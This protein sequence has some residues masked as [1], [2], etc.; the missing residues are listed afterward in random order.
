MQ[1]RLTLL[2]TW[3]K[4]TL[5]GTD[6]GDF[7]L[8]P[9]AGDASFRRYFRLHTQNG[10]RYIVMDA[11]PEKEDCRPFVA[12]TRAWSAYNICVPNIY[13]E[14]IEQGF[15][16]LEDFGDT[17][18]FD[19]VCQADTKTQNDIYSLA[20]DALQALQ[21]MP[22]QAL[23]HNI[24]DRALLMRELRLFSD[25]LI[26]DALS[27]NL[28]NE[29]TQLLEAGF[30]LL[31][32]NALSQAL[33]VVHRDYHS[34]NLMIRG[35]QKIGI[36]DFQDAVI[37]P[38]TYDLVSLLR[39][40]Y[41]QLEPALIKKLALGFKSNSSNEQIRALPEAIFLRHF[42]LMGIQRH[43]KAAGIFARLA[44][45]DGKLGYLQD[46][47]RTFSYITEVCSKYGELQALATFLDE[48]VEPHIQA[49]IDS[50]TT[51]RQTRPQEAAK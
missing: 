36:I 14:D 2:N 38:Y 18:L 19:T 5:T 48:E 40:C 45:R 30:E 47:P 20:L 10:G 44:L 50:H 7:D 49:F 12:V 39:D 32:E 27:I 21:A 35:D 4:R 26:A 9:V 1:D 41:I 31:I 46:I 6:Q 24:Y 42:D 51:S 16:L 34:R 43:M 13:F 17:Q 15:L 22:T 28:T 29:Q 37:G 23:T 33:C 8:E 11:P 3:L 25:W